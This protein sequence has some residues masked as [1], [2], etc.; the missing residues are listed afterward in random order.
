MD[1]QDIL[2][3]FRE[4][5]EKNEQEE[6]RRRDAWLKEHAALRQQVEV[7]LLP[8]LRKA[9]VKEYK[10]WLKGYIKRGGRPTHVYDYPFSNRED[11]FYVA[12]ADLPRSFALYGASA[13]HIIVPEGI[14]VESG[15]WG[16]CGF[17][18]MDGSVGPNIVPLFND[19]NFT[20]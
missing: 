10:K 20:E 5:Y 9:T 17:F 14:K 12:R 6:Q 1:I 3:K 18:Y 15:D 11:E 19:I 16:H 7:E 2:D 4:D 8:L 13:I